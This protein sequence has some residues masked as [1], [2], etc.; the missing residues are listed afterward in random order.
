MKKRTFGSSRFKSHSIAKAHTNGV[1]FV[2][3]TVILRFNS[4]FPCFAFDAFLF[5]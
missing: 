5:A 3:Y 4:M 2:I 1:R